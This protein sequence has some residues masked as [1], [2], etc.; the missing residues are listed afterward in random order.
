MNN[1]CK[2]IFRTVHEGKWL[3]VEYK[4]K[5]EKITRYWIGIKDIDVDKRSLIVDGFGPIFISKE[6]ANDKNRIV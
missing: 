5:D 4:N 2:E 6:N 3:S 1:N